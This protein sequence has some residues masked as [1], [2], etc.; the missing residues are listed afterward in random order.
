MKRWLFASLVPLAVSLPSVAQAQTAEGFSVNKFEPAERGSEWFT[1]DSL[2][3]RGKVRPAFGITPH[4]QYRPLA[5]YDNGVL[6]RSVVRNVLTFHTGGSVNLFDRVRVGV[7]IPLIAYVDGNPDSLGLF[8]APPP[9]E[10]AIGDL[11]AAADVRLAGTHGDAFTLA[12]GV[13]FWAPT[14]N[15]EAYA[16][17][18]K[19]RVQG[20]LQAAGEVG[21]VVYAAHAGFTFRDRRGTFADVPIGSEIVFGA[22]G[23]L[24]ALD[25]K[26]VVGPEVYAS[27][28]VD[29]AFTTR[30]TPLDA[31][32]GLHYSITDSF[33]VGA[34]IGTGFTRGAG[35]PQFHGMIGLDYYPKVVF[36]ADGDGSEDEKDACPNVAGVPDPDPAKHG[37]PRPP[38]P[39][40]P[41]TDSDG[42]LDKNDACPKVPG[43]AT[44]DPKTNGCPADRDGD[45]VYDRDDACPDVAGVATADPKTNGCPPDTD[46]DGVL[47]KDDACPT[48]PGLKTSDPKTNGCPDPD[49]DKDGILNDADACPDEPGTADP[50]AKKNGCPKAIV[51]A[52]KIEIRD[53]VR[54]KTNSAEILGKDS[55]EILLAVKKVLDEHPEIKKVRVEGH[56]D[57]QGAAAANKK[58]SLARAASI[59]KWL[60]DHKIAKDRL[61]SAGLGLE[62]PIGDNKSEEG[63]KQNRRVEFHI[64]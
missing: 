47:D 40:E 25:K 48:V 4:Y 19:V 2:D 13:R 27:T 49:R 42:I 50:D 60:T 53:Q 56:T 1:A 37:C 10:Q 30:G 61:T 64:E 63:R 46:G 52:G 24:R 32:L 55:E 26:L 31:V 7:S 29:S 45:G 28:V 58:L 12:T 6:F 39:P 57:N 8:L 3:L 11:R 33:R 20:R 22:S 54:F 44:K 34:G 14:G 16:G 35:A 38:P 41:D 18:G 36:D 15:K 62:K 5:T 23:G 21:A 9:K 43:I 17:D 59:V 51:K